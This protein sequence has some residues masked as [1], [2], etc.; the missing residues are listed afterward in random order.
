[1]TLRFN[2]IY[3]IYLDRKIIRLKKLVPSKSYGDY[4]SKVKINDNN[5]LKNV[6][7]LFTSRHVL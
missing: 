3:N 7:S 5:I 6:K 4:K 1:M 2:L